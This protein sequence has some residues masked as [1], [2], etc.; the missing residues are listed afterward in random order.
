MVD[1]VAAGGSGDVAIQATALRKRFARRVQLEYPPLMVG[2]GERVAIIGENGAGKT[3]LLRIL[4]G[5]MS[6][7]LGRVQRTGRIGYCPQHPG[8]LSLLTS[9]EHLA[10]FGAGAGLPASAAVTRGRIVLERLRFEEDRDVPVR[11][12][13]GGT[14]QKL[15]LALALLGAP[16]IL[17]LDEPYQ[18]F[19]NGSYINFWELVDGWSAEGK[20]VIVVTH[21]LGELDRVDTVVELRAPARRR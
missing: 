6:P 19:D 21:L 5:V 11:E 9:S 20:A 13:S 7:D 2:R 16:D 3:T 4:A 14:Q 12:L 15:N 17:L 1:V 18:G 10:L 8:L